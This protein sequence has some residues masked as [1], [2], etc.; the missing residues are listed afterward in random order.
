MTDATGRMRRQQPVLRTPAS[1]CIAPIAA[2]AAARHSSSVAT[3]S[4]TPRVSRTGRGRLAGRPSARGGRRT[5]QRCAGAK[6][7]KPPRETSTHSPTP[8]APGRRPQPETGAQ[9]E[10]HSSP[11][12]QKYTPPSSARGGASLHRTKHHVVQRNDQVRWD[13]YN[14]SSEND[15]QEAV[16]PVRS[17]T[18]SASRLLLLRYAG[19]ATVHRGRSG[20]VVRLSAATVQYD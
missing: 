4:N 10:G 18:T 16:A 19:Q 13:C 20:L 9:A 14:D 3:P 1:W 6:P 5:L 17:T 12:N 8:P 2:C 15:L 7:T 11:M